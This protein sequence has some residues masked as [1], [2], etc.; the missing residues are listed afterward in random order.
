MRKE[1]IIKIT[2]EELVNKLG[3]EQLEW[4]RKVIYRYRKRDL[5][6]FNVEFHLL[7]EIENA[8]KNIAGR[9][10]FEDLTEETEETHKIYI[11]DKQ[12]D[13]YKNNYFAKTYWTKFFKNEVI[14]TIRH[15]I[16]HAYVKERFRY[17]CKIDNC[18][19]DASI[20]FLMY[21][22]FFG[23]DSGH[24]CAD[25][26]KYS[27]TYKKVKECKDY[28]EFLD[29]VI[30]I[31]HDLND[32][33]RK[34]EK[35]YDNKAIKLSFGDRNSS[36]V[37]AIESRSKYIVKSNDK[38]VKI[39]DIEAFVFRIGSATPIYIIEELIDKKLK[40]TEVA[41]IREIKKIYMKKVGEKIYSKEIILDEA[42]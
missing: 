37:K 17:M 9:Y 16:L 36:L 21:L 38:E 27:E 13:D 14:D 15:E 41:E 22:Q 32:L 26:Y 39:M 40:N 42:S 33:Q 6:F 12:L 5:L 3:A 31:I 4:F 24:Y 1:E 18:E 7:S 19:A 23:V 11:L 20:I 2:N 28:N 8:D 30:D 34:L 25:S 35:K 10:I 29:L